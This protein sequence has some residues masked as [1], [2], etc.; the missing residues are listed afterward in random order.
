MNQTLAII[1]RLSGMILILGFLLIPCV[2]IIRYFGAPA[3]IFALASEI[4][5]CFFLVFRFLASENSTF[6]EF[7]RTPTEVL[8]ESP[9]IVA[10][11]MS[12][13][14]VASGIY[15]VLTA[16]TPPAG[17]PDAMTQIEQTVAGMIFTCLGIGLLGTTL[18]VIISR[19]RNARK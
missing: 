4:L 2:L 6:A 1:S 8:F 10:A 18:P 7:L 11:L 17:N 12:L 19:E 14:F 9:P 16:E 13:P 15:I 3:A 5:V